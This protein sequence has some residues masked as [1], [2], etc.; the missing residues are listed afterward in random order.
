MK[1]WENAEGAGVFPRQ[2]CVS[3]TRLFSAGLLSPFPQK[4]TKIGNA[5]FDLGDALGN[6]VDPNFADDILVFAHSNPEVAQIVYRF[7]TAVGQAGLRLNVNKTFA[8][9]SA[10]R[11]QNTFVTRDG[12]ILKVLDWNHGRKWLGCIVTACGSMMQ[13]V[14]LKYH[15]NTAR[16]VPTR[17]VS[18][19]LQYKT[20]SRCRKLN[21]FNVRVSGVVWFGGGDRPCPRNNSVHLTAFFEKGC[22]SM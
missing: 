1:S 2:N 8:L 3:S 14:D 9:T 20:T 19:L 16:N 17:I 10:A 5:D 12:L 15:M 11:P 6:L 13:H 4:R 18:Q 21:N 22:G 7:V